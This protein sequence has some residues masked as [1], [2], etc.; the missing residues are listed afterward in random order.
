MRRG[1]RFAAAS[2]TVLLVTG[3]TSLAGLSGGGDSGPSDGGNPFEHDAPAESDAPAMDTA[4]VDSAPADV[5]PEATPLP[6]TPTPGMGTLCL[7]V[8]VDSAANVPGY[9]AFTGAGTLGIDGQGFLLAYLF[10]K[11]PADPSNGHVLPSATI[12]FPT[13]TGSQITIDSLPAQVVGTAA[14]GTYYMFAFFEDNDSASRGTG[15]LATL[16]GDFIMK[17]IQGPNGVTYPQVTLTAG[18]VTMAQGLIDP[19]RQLV[20]NVHADQ[21]LLS[22][23]ANN[24]AVHGDGPAAFFVY[25]GD[26]TGSNITML[27]VG[28]AACIDLKLQTGAVA[29]SASFGVLSTGSHNLFGNLYDYN[30]PTITNPLTSGTIIS[31]FQ[32]NGGSGNGTP[33]TI[34][35]TTW[36]SNGDE[37]MDSVWQALTGSVTDPLHCQ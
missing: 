36:S 30:L 14:P 29:V 26:I 35:P 7:T 37:P 8:S 3:C 24:P 6:C 2:I 10:D 17:T 12:R 15:L 31:P 9:S 21:T 18:Q 1:S 25:D 32:S 19:L 23:A 22:A 5:P 34:D 27:D 20:L 16:P 13:L 33:V 4:I 28:Q 11:D